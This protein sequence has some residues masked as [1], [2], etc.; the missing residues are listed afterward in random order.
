MTE[1]DGRRRVTFFYLRARK[2]RAER[3]YPSDA[4]VTFLTPS[5]DA[6]PQTGAGGEG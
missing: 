6:P 2:H 3:L 1:G 4:P 5:P